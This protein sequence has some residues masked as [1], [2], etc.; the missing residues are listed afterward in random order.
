MK[1][2]IYGVY[3]MKYYEQCIAVFDTVKE[4][5]KYFNTTENTISPEIT[6]GNKRDGRYLIA[7]IE[8]G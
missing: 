3:D 1:K 8:E 4:I 6:R 5:A 2:Y 7:R